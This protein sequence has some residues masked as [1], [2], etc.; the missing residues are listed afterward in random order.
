MSDVLRL[1]AAEISKDIG[2]PYRDY[3]AIDLALRTGKAPVICHSAH[4][5]CVDRGWPAMVP[6]FGRSALRSRSPRRII[7]TPKIAA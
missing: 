5:I 7:I 6:S 2:T 4:H 3:D 1:M